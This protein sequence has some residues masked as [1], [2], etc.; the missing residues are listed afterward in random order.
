MVRF[1]KMFPMRK[2]RGK[3]H[4]PQWNSEAQNIGQQRLSYCI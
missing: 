4:V 1:E 3:H 2:V